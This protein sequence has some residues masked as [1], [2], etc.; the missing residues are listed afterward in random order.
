MYTLP[1]GRIPLKIGDVCVISNKRHPLYYHR[2]II[3]QIVEGQIVQLVFIQYR[4]KQLVGKLHT[5]NLRIYDNSV[6]TKVVTR[7]KLFLLVGELPETYVRNNISVEDCP[8]E[9][10]LLPEL[11][12]IIFDNDS[13]VVSGASEESDDSNYG[14]CMLCQSVGMIGTYCVSDECV[15]SGSIYA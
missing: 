14:S 4:G 7:G 1:Q 9:A 15:D 3:S 8:L 11:D 13:S 2:G 5:N 12:D 10:M 6:A